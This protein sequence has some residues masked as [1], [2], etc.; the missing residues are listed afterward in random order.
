MLL[1]SEQDIQSCITMHDAINAMKSAFIQLSNHQAVLPLRTTIPI[2]NKDAVALSMPAF[3][4]KEAQLGVKLVTAFPHN[5]QR[6]LPTIHG[7]IV[8]FDANTGIPQAFMDARYLTALRTGAIAGLATDLLAK[9]EATSLAVI[10]AGAQAPA[11]IEA[12]SCVRNIKKIYLWSRQHEHTLTFAKTL[13]HRFEVHAC[14]TVEESVQSAD[15]ICTV[16]P[17]EEPLVHFKDV[18]PDVH[19]NAMGSHAKTMREIDSDIMQRAAIIVD[20]ISAALSEAGEIIHAIQLHLIQQENLTEIGPLINQPDDV[21]K[22]KMTVFKSVG[23]AIQDIS[24]AS[25]VYQQAIQKKIGFTYAIGGT[26]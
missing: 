18:Q 2:K 15:I 22:Q 4:E 21:L 14:K 10:G 1:L 23:L 16:T 13:E 19:I 11:Q 9:D 6:N 12:I 24:I 7:V 5:S 25:C 26:S 20:Q 8:L 17:S 3:L